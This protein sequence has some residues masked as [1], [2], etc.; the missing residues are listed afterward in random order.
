MS[1]S[2]YAPQL[3]KS[4]STEE[5]APRVR[6]FLLRRISAPSANRAARPDQARFLRHL[7]R[8]AVVQ[9]EQVHSRQEARRDP[10]AWF[11]SKDPSCR[12]R[13][14]A[15]AASDRAHATATA[16]AMFAS[17]TN[18]SHENSAAAPARNC[19]KTLSATDSV[20]RVFRSHAYSPDQRNVLPVHA[21]HARSV[22]PARLP[23]FEFGF[24][25]IV[26]DDADQFYRR[27]KARAHEPRRRPNRRADRRALPRES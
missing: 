21:L 15:D 4:S 17:R 11:R 1:S 5:Q 6:L 3:K 7:P 12:R 14:T 18:S 25:K 24:G 13:Q 19:S 8:F 10:C 26:A 2:G 27:K 20:S 23:K 9:D 22:D 16:G